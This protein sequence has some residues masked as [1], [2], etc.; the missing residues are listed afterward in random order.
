MGLRK[1]SLHDN[2]IT[3][4]IPTTLGFLRDLHNVYLFNNRFSGAVPASIGGC[5]WWCCGGIPKDIM[6]SP[7]LLLLNLSYNNLS[8]GHI[9][10]AFA[11]SS[12][13]SSKIL[14]N[15][16]NKQAMTRSYKIVFLPQPHAQPTQWARS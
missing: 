1:L 5:I 10:N 12:S 4:Q 13:S 6:A 2:T 9:P 11:G 16:E 7:S 8:R 3:G 14:T 15:N